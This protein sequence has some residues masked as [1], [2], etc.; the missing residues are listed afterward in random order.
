VKASPRSPD[1]F[2]G[3]DVEWLAADRASHLAVFITAGFGPI[4]AA[5]R[6]WRMLDAAHAFIRELPVHTTA[7]LLARAP[8]PDDFIAF[9]S[10]G[11][12]VYDWDDASGEY[13]LAARPARPISLAEADLPS[14]LGGAVCVVSDF[15]IGADVVADAA[16]RQ[17]FTGD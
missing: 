2:K 17:A 5:F 7:E 8:R 4:P 6:D 14:T 9:A 3:N 12:F 16:W 11:L 10:R 13:H 15:R 1:S